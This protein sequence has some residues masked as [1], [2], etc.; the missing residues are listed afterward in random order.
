MSIWSLKMVVIGNGTLEG[1]LGLGEVKR[2]PWDQ[3]P[4]KL[5]CGGSSLSLIPILSHWWGSC[6]ATGMRQLS[7]SQE[8]DPHQG[9]SM[10]LIWSQASDFRSYDR[11]I[12][13]F[14]LPQPMMFCWSCSID[15]HG[16]RT[17]TRWGQGVGSFESGVLSTFCVSPIP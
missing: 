10:L 4:Q 12:L 6:E 3:C 14:K 13:Q 9:L 16:Y 1:S 17:C 8:D 5:R 15:C 2:G 7:R 11:G